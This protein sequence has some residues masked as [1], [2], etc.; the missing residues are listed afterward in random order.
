MLEFSQVIDS[1]LSFVIKL[2]KKL[3]YVT[4]KENR[5]PYNEFNSD[6]RVSIGFIRNLGIYSKLSTCSAWLSSQLSLTE[7][8]RAEQ[9][10]SFS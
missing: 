4:S 9:K 8:Q 7:R 3:P 5:Q 1:Q 10:Y 2:A 6:K